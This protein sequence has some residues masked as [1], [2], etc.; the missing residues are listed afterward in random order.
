MAQAELAKPYGGPIDSSFNIIF[1]PDLD[2]LPTAKEFEVTKFLDIPIIT[3]AWGN[4]ETFGQFALRNFALNR[5]DAE[6]LDMLNQSGFTAGWH[7][8]FEIDTRTDQYQ[9]FH[10][11]VGASLVKRAMKEKGW[12]GLDLLVFT[13]ISSKIDTAERV[14]DILHK[15]NLPVDKTLFYGLA[16]AGT[17]AAMADIT[18]IKDFEG[19]NVGLVSV[20]TLSGTQFDPTNVQTYW[21]FGNGGGAF[22]WTPGTD[23][24][25]H[26]GH[27][28][29]EQDNGMITV[30]QPYIYTLP[31]E[32]LPRENW[33][34]WYEFVNEAS[35]KAFAFFH[36]GIAM[37]MPT[38]EGSSVTIMNGRETFKFFI[39]RGPNHLVDFFTANKFPELGTALI[40]Q[41]S[42]A[43]VEGMNNSYRKKR[44]ELMKKG[45]QLPFLDLRW[46][47]D[48]TGTC[49]TSSQT[50]IKAWKEGVKQGYYQPNVLTPLIGLGIGSTIH[51]DVI[52]FLQP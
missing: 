34:P 28:W 14:A 36:G 7:N 45:I 42:K 27:A 33:L 22:V 20:E 47:M 51:V 52:E 26:G 17:S 11:Q 23:I 48:K 46:V 21:T 38:K 32:T 40:H 13:S 25:H 43:V 15:E 31:K 39:S 6:N 29:V 50:I 3:T 10:A 19:K 8:D 4:R 44:I 12:K 24:I 5:L 9:E 1:Q 37:E 41:P 49:N 18:R 16:C 30:P 35:E 2:K